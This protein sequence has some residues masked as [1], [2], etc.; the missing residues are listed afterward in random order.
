MLV[1]LNW[2]LEAGKWKILIQPL[3]RFSFFR[4]FKSVLAGCSVTM[5]TPN[6]VGE[7]GGRILYVKDENRIDAIPLTILGSIS[8]LTITFIGGTIGLLLLRATGQYP[9]LLTVLPLFAM[10]VMIFV[11]VV[12]GGFLLLIFFR[13]SLIAAFTSQFKRLDKV[14]VHLESL[15]SFSGKQLLRIMLLSFLRYMVFILQYVLLLKVMHVGIS[16]GTAF[17]LLTVF[18][19]LM[20]IAPTIGFTELPVRVAASLTILQIYSPNVIGIQAAA[21][22]IWLFNLVVPAVAGSLFILGLKIMKDK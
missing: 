17:C 18:Y 20:A 5:L 16:A 3:E 12:I 15:K 10:N 6:R 11:S 13:T 4:A 8:Q 21:L 22:G 9:R 1:P 19:L 14:T 2:G 7:Y